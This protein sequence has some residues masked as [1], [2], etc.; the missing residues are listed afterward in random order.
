MA[1]SAKRVAAIDTKQPFPNY[2]YYHNAYA[3]LFVGFGRACGYPALLQESIWVYC[4]ISICLYNNRRGPLEKNGGNGRRR[5]CYSL[6]RLHWHRQRSNHEQEIIDS[7]AEVDQVGSLE[8]ADQPEHVSWYDKVYWQAKE[9]LYRAW[10]GLNTRCRM[11]LF[12]GVLCNFQ[13]LKIT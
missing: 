4:G 9:I 3:S 1:C 5:L 6:P 12:Y 11:V 13:Q 8:S 2:A 7:L 10:P